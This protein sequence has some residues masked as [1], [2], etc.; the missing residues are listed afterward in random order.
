MK[1][2]IK[3]KLKNFG[4]NIINNMGPLKAL[5]YK[6]FGTLVSVNTG[7][8]VAAITFDDGP[9]PVWTPRILDVLEEFNVKATF[10]VIGKSANKHPDIVKEA[11]R[12]GHAIANHTWD[13]PCLSLLTRKKRVDQI[14][15]CKDLISEFDSLLFRPPF[16]CQSPGSKLDAYI[17]G[18]SVVAWNMHASDWLDRQA[19]E[20]A[21]DLNS[22]LQPGSIILLHDAQNGKSREKMITGLIGFLKSNSDYR[23]VTVP[24]LLN[25]GEKKEIIWKRTPKADEFSPHN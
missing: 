8:K 16:G 1:P 22:K 21:H 4:S 3:T 20:I 11:Y 7:K 14:E 24:D 10:F 5:R 2:E 17:C 13:H 23:F 15:K 25:Y 6:Y 9:D 18:Y 12:S 19:D